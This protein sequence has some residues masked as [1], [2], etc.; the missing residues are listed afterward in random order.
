MHLLLYGVR[1]VAISPALRP[2]LLT[3]VRVV[4]MDTERN[5]QRRRRQ[6]KRL[7]RVLT[8][9][10]LRVTTNTPN[11]PPQALRRRHQFTSQTR[12]LTQPL[13]ASQRIRMSAHR[14]HR[15]L[16][17]QRIR[18]PVRRERRPPTHLPLHRTVSTSHTCVPTD[19]RP[20]SKLRSVGVT[21]ATETSDAT[22]PA[23]NGSWSAH[24]LTIADGCGAHSLCAIA[25]CAISRDV[26]GHG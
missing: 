23:P 15:P 2:S 22:A 21:D 20:A 11:I 24:W 5:R 9:R 25:H 26:A 10:C 13:L 12:V 16:S 1:T 4:W 8:R 17:L 6:R 7:S 14:I 19:S 18:I 3:F